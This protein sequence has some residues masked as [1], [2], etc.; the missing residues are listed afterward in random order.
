MPRI[1]LHVI[2]IAMYYGDHAR[3]RFHAKYGEHEAQ[4]GIAIGELLHGWLPRRPRVLVGEWAAARRPELEE[5]WARAE[6]EEPLV[7]IEPLP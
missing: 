2:V 1:A 6:R 3:P 7:T 5:N 4:V